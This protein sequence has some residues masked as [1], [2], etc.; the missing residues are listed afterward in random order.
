L[1]DRFELP[2]VGAPLSSGLVRRLQ[3]ER[4][5]QRHYA[6]VLG[7]GSP[8]PRR[9]HEQHGL[10]AARTDLQHDDRRLRRM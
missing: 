3:I 7:V 9:V 6:G 4:G 10:P 1:H 8:M 2:V 5:L